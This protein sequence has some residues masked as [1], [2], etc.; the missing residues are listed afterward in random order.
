MLVGPPA[1][2][3]AILV[4]IVLRVAAALVIG[5]D[6]VRM[7]EFGTIAHNV[8]DGHGYSYHAVGPDGRAQTDG[9]M[10]DQV[11]TGPR[12][13]SAFVPPG[14]TAFVIAAV[15]PGGDR[16]DVV[17]L[18]QLLNLLAAA[19]TTVLVARLGR[20]LAGTAAGRAAAWVFALY[21]PFVYAA[22][23]VS[24]VNL[25]L[26]V[27]ALVLLGLVS[28]ARRTRLVHTLPA[29]LALGALCLLRAEAMLLVPLAAAWLALA[30]RRYR[31][32][33]AGVAAVLLVAGALVL[34]GAWIVR[35]NVVFSPP[36][37]TVATSGGFN[38]WIGNHAGASGSQKDYTIPDPTRAAVEA[39]PATTDYEAQV[40]RL[41]LT[42]ALRWMSDDPLGVLLL[43]A[44][45]LLLMTTV[46][47]HDERAYH[48]VYLGAWLLLLALGLGG[49][50]TSRRSGPRRWL[51]YGLLAFTVAI[52]T[53]FFVLA[54]H[55][56]GVEFVLVLYAG[57]M[58]ARL[59]RGRRGRRR[60]VTS[61]P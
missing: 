40:D 4:G 48:P 2:A 59:V 33:R 52:P 21:P 41:Y 24:A 37:L 57:A 25:Y 54:R 3:A 49:L 17:R 44:K 38:L 47:V 26:P 36:V 32:G 22:T 53:L 35:N 6:D 43:D 12:L 31:R 42:E 56:L 39:V 14:Y 29:A 15:A 8:V 20:L 1:L 45:K 34:P 55:K 18:L 46:D 9:Q 60:A 58:V 7:H 16:A 27:L 11:L 13:P 10:G 19:A 23:Q 50:L 5:A 30:R 51:M 61:T 28:A